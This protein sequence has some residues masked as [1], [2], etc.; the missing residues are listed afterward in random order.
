MNLLFLLGL[1][2]V[3]YLSTRPA[4][5]APNAS[6]AS[7][8]SNVPSGPAPEDTVQIPVPEVPSVPAYGTEVVPMP[9]PTYDPSLEPGYAPSAPKP[10]WMGQKNGVQFLRDDAQ[11]RALFDAAV[12]RY[13][14][15]KIE[16]IAE[17]SLGIIAFLDA[18]GA[19]FMSAV[20]NAPG[21]VVMMLVSDVEKIMSKN[22]PAMISAVVTSS[23]AS[24]GIGSQLVVVV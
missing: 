20:E 5:A 13:A 14:D 2:V 4:E 3:V 17:T 7:N 1:G 10:W 23:A 12:Y 16:Q 8:A 22:P 24:A 19:S 15:T 18:S 21:K 9:F 6:N 11:T